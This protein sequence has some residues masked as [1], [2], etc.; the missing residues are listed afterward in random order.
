MTIPVT[1]APM[2][3]LATRP[4]T[5]LAWFALGS[6]PCGARSTY[7]AASPRDEYPRVTLT[8]TEVPIGRSSRIVTVRRIA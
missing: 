6:W 4:L 8:V 5:G 2:M 1:V 3:V 7:A